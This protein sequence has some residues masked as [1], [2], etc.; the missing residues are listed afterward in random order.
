MSDKNIIDNFVSEAAQQYHVAAPGRVIDEGRR[1]GL[2]E[3]DIP[4]ASAAVV[5]TVPRIY[6][7]RASRPYLSKMLLSFATHNGAYAAAILV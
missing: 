1:A 5:G 4:F 2:N 7:K 3:F 6:T